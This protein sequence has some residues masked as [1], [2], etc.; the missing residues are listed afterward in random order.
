MNY[1]CFQTALPLLLTGRS[2]TTPAYFKGLGKTAHP[3]SSRP[4]SRSSSSSQ[5]VLTGRAVIRLLMIKPRCSTEGRRAYG[6]HPQK[7]RRRASQ[8]FHFHKKLWRLALNAKQ[9]AP[10]TPLGRSRTHWVLTA[11][12]AQ[13]QQASVT[14]WMR[15]GTKYGSYL[16]SLVANLLRLFLVPTTR[17]VPAI[18]QV[19]ST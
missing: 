18:M 1:V 6:P 13:M 4:P 9:P 14:V 7:D 17:L 19:A 2:H 15:K 12:L 11:R 5:S 16:R 8:S 10:H 3:P